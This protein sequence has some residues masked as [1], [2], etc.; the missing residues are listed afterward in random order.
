MPWARSSLTRNRRSAPTSTAASAARSWPR[1][2][3]TSPAV[4]RPCRP[5][6]IHRPNCGRGSTARLLMKA[7]LRSSSCPSARARVLSVSMRAIAIAASVAAVAAIGSWQVLSRSGSVGQDTQ[8]A[9][10]SCQHSSSCTSIQLLGRGTRQADAVLLIRGQDAAGSDAPEP[11]RRQPA[12]LCLLAA[13][14]DGRPAGVLSFAVGAANSQQ[15][16]ERGTLPLPYAVTTA[17]ALT[18]ENGTTIPAAPSRLL[19]IAPAA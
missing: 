8:A 15:P 10:R 16:I 5:V 12:D 11:G 6:R 1:S 18:R 14:R 9:I 3:A 17:F 13:P 7:A 4:W 2:S 19:A